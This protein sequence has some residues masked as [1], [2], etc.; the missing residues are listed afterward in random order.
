VKANIA[1]PGCP[2]QRVHEGVDHYVSVAVPYQA[3][4]EWNMHPH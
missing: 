2:K 3:A 4:V 1:K